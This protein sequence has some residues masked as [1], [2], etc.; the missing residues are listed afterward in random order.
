MKPWL[1]YWAFLLDLF[2]IGSFGTQR[3][4]SAELERM[5]FRPQSEI[6]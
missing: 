5:D 3:G 4:S 1:T 6:A 2:F